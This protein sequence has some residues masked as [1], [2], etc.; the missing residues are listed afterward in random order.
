MS[1]H[2][3]IVK[4][5]QEIKAMLERKLWLAK[6]SIAFQKGTNKNTV[7]KLARQINAIDESISSFN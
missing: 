4:S 3:S 1:G 5:L 6:T 2:E 7:M